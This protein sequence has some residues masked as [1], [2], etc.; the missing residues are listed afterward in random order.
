[1]AAMPLILD[2]RRVITSN[3]HNRFFRPMRFC[4]HRE[5]PLVSHLK[6]HPLQI[7][8]SIMTRLVRTLQMNIHKTM[9][10]NRSQDKLSALTIIVRP[11]PGLQLPNVHPEQSSNPEFSRKIRDHQRVQTPLSLK[12]LDLRPGGSS[13]PHQH[14]IRRDHTLSPPLLVCWMISQNLSGF[15][16]ELV[17]HRRSNNGLVRS[18]QRLSPRNITLFHARLS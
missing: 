8:Q 17:D 13:V 6:S 2:R 4:Q 11:C 1:M 5:E 7:E 18:V 16:A 3:R 14:E 10:S 9:L 12:S 15:E